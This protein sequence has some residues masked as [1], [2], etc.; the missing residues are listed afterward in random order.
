MNTVLVTVAGP[1]QRQDL[2]V[3]AETP[4][5][6]LMPTLLTVA[7]VEGGNGDMAVSRPGEPPLPPKSS[8]AECGVVDG[9]VLVVAAPPKEE[10]PARPE[11]EPVEELEDY[12]RREE[13]V[14]LK[15]RAAFPLRRTDST[16]PEA[17]RLG[18]RW[19][20]VTKAFFSRVDPASLKPQFP[21][22]HRDDAPTPGPGDLTV[23]QPPSRMDRARA[24][25]RETSYQRRL[26]NMTAEPRLRRCA[27]IAVVSPKGGV[28][29]TTMTALLGALLVRVRHERIVAVDTN[30]DYG[31]LGRA[32]T[33]DHR[34]FVDD[35]VD[36][37][38]HPDLAVTELDRKLGR[39]FD[40]LMVLPAPTDPS[41]MARLDEAAYAKVFGRLKTLVGGLV[42]DCGTGLQEPAARAAIAAADQIVLVSDAEPS[43]ASLVAEAARLLKRAGPPMYLVVNKVPKRGSRLDLEQFSRA[44]PDARALLVVDADQRAASSLAAGDFSWDAAPDGWQLALRELAAVM[45][46]DWTDLGLA[47]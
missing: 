29:K 42:L 26:E 6:Q 1:E 45:V 20:A 24:S 35:F 23:V 31:S 37:L 5:E 22:G 47:A 43:T 10:Q 11:P 46:A 16:L 30:P 8:L 32:L 25:W 21:P 13:A 39:G 34:V 41:R 3:P 19:G 14:A 44:V 40:G 27:T 4:I 36:L 9:T 17:P 18:E 12:V 28:G 2:A 15:R 33:P 38:D 7:G